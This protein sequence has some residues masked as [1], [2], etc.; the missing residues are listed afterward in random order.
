VPTADPTTLSC[1]HS[2]TRARERY[3]HR[4][5]TEGATTD[6]KIANALASLTIATCARDH[7]SGPYGVAGPTWRLVGNGGHRLALDRLPAH[8]GDPSPLNP[9]PPDLDG[10]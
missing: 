7:V 8:H 2:P 1:S 3:F 10:T 4:H 5:L 6:R 9:G